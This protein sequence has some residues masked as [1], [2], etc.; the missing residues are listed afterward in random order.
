MNGQIPQVVVTP[1]RLA[2]TMASLHPG[3]PIRRLQVDAA[4]IDL[5]AGI[6]RAHFTQATAQHTWPSTSPVAMLQARC[7]APMASVI[8][9]IT[10]TL[11]LA[12]RQR[13]PGRQPAFVASPVGDARRHMQGGAVPA[14]AVLQREWDGICRFLDAASRSPPTREDRVCELPSAE[15]QCTY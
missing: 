12:F 3:W 7:E 6:S 9:L 2:T 1:P 8:R 10:H 14:F 11:L 15:L 13:A 5:P 4:V